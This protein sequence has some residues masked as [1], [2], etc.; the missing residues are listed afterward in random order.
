M[1]LENPLWSSKQKVETL[2]EHKDTVVSSLAPDAWTITNC[3]SRR[4]PRRTVPPLLLALQNKGD[5]AMAFCKQTKWWKDE[6]NDIYK[7]SSFQSD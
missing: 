6:S 7:I 3:R 2:M 4:G 1:G 5:T